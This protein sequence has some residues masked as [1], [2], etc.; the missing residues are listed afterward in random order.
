VGTGVVGTGTVGTE[1][2]S[3][4]VIGR[5]SVD[6]R[7][8]MRKGT[9]DGGETLRGSFREFRRIRAAARSLVFQ[10]RGRVHAA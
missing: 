8:P 9:L 5:P 3:E 2:F 10:P 7:P 1:M 4:I 6:L